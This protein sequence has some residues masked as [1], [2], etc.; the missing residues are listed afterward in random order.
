MGGGDETDGELR[1]VLAGVIESIKARESKAKENPNLGV[2]HKFRET[3]LLLELSEALLE[4]ITSHGSSYC[5][6]FQAEKLHIV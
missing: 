3:P 4:L 5:K 1:D 2:R 6:E